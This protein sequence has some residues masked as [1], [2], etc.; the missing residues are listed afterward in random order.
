[1]A[2]GDISNQLSGVSEGLDRFL[3]ALDASSMGLGSQDALK[4]IQARAEMKRLDQ[5]KRFKAKIEKMEKLH[6]LGKILEQVKIM[7][8]QKV[9]KA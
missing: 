6:K 4:K 2:N 3:E 7:T 1:M 8:E 5:E 9:G